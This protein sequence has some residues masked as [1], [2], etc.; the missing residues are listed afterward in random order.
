MFTTKCKKF[1]GEIENYLGK[2]WGRSLHLKLNGI[3]VS[4]RGLLCRDNQGEKM[5]MNCYRNETTK[6]KNVPLIFPFSP[7]NTAFKLL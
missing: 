2:T 3:Q 4:G 1:K 5:G 6:V 7:P